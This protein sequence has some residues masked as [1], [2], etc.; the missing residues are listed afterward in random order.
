MPKHISP[1][2][3]P[4]GKSKLY[5]KIEQLIKLNKINNGMY[6]EPYAGG[7]GVAFG[8][9]YNKVVDYIII[10]DYDLSIYA[11]WHSVLYNTD[12]FIQLIRE[13][14]ITMNE[15]YRQ[16]N[17]QLSKNSLSNNLLLLG[18][19]TFFLNRTNRSG[20]IKGGVI[21]GKDQTGNYKLNCRFNKEK[22]IK[23][24]EFIST[25]KKQVE[26]L[27]LK[28]ENLI[29]E[30][31][32]NLPKNSFIFFDPP[33][34]KK[35][36]GLYT[37]FYNHENHVDLERLIHSYINTPYIITYD[38]VDEINNIYTQYSKFVFKINYSASTI[39]QGSEILIF[40]DDLLPYT[41]LNDI[42]G[43]FEI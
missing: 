39:K 9:L 32:I 18:F 13:T 22:L 30:R 21:G 6:V 7:A 24:I 31:L 17:I 33:Y 11:F 40:N 37:D 15:W 23:Q 12:N 20:I 14:P 10:N 4:G 19:S 1:L 43:L 25:Y 34:Y 38:N 26:L 35:G 2:R 29:T 42:K 28:A 27:N 5:N 41:S 8:L 36:F 16:K 3:Y